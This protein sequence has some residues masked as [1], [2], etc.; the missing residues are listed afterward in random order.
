MLQPTDPDF[1]A[2]W[3]D[4]LLV[5][6]RDRNK[7]HSLRNMLA[8]RPAFL[9]CG[10]P[11]AKHLPLERL[12]ERGVWTM[13]VNNAAGHPQFRANAFV[14]SDPPLKFSHSIWFDPAVMKFVP[15]PK[16]AK[17]RRMLREK[18]N[19][20]FRKSDKTVV[21]CPNVWGFQRHSWLRP[22]DEFFLTDGACWGNQDAGTKLTGEKKTVCTMLLGIR[23]LRYLGAGRVYLV[24]VDFLMRPGEVY[25][26]DQ[27]K[28]AG[29]CDSN[30]QQFIVVNEWL[31]KMQADGVFDKFN[32]PLFNCN[33]LSGLRAFPHVPFGDAVDDCTCDVEQQPDL[34]DW[35]SKT[36]CPK[37]QSWEV[38]SGE[39]Y[40]CMTCGE[41]WPVAAP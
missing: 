9:V 1:T 32:M 26:F 20:V 19:G 21:D 28:H 6:D 5:F 7:N 31:C 35:Y 40:T 25:S 38:R 16:M 36:Q 18:W 30:N 23:L 29:G 3:I 39:D 33:Q 8:G 27:G 10:G 22:N 15:L 34:A 11:S 24:G 2:K 17:G 37:C 41:K 12:N 13:G 4:P 14:C